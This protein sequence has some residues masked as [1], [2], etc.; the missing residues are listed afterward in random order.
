[1]RA[2]LA[3]DL[4]TAS[5]TNHGPLP[6]RRPRHHGREAAPGKRKA[7]HLVR[8]AGPGERSLVDGA[9]RPAPGRCA[10]STSSRRRGRT[11]SERTG[12]AATTSWADQSSSARELSRGA[13]PSASVAPDV[14]APLRRRRPPPH[15][16]PADCARD[17]RGRALVGCASTAAARRRRA[18]ADAARAS[19]RPRHLPALLQRLRRQRRVVL[20]ELSEL[21]G[22]R[23]PRR[24]R[25]SRGRRAG[26]RSGPPLLRRP[27]P[28]GLRHQPRRLDRGASAALAHP[29][30]ASRLL[31]VVPAA[32]AIR[33]GDRIERM[34]RVETLADTR[35]I[36][37]ALFVPP[38]GGSGRGATASSSPTR[39]ARCSAIL[40]S[41]RRSRTPSKPRA[42]AARLAGRLD[43]GARRPLFRV[44]VGEAMR[45][46]LPR[47]T[48]TVISGAA[49]GVQ[50][51]S[52]QRVPRRRSTPSV[53]A[54]PGASAPAPCGRPRPAQ[55]RRL[56][57]IPRRA[58]RAGARGRRPMATPDYL[59][60]LTCENALLHFEWGDEGV[61]ESALR[62]SAATTRP[63]SSSP[64]TTSTPSSTPTRRTKSRS[65]RL[66]EPDAD[67][68]R[69]R[70]QVAAR[71][72]RAWP[73]D[74]PRRAA[75][76]GSLPPARQ[77]MRPK[78]RASASSAARQPRRVARMRSNGTGEPPRC[79]WPSTVTRISC[80]MRGASSRARRSPAPP[81]RGWPS[82]ASATAGRRRGRRPVRALGDHHEREGLAARG[83]LLDLGLDR[84][85]PIGDLRHAG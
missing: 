70:D 27:P 64:R 54:F 24:R 37:S 53:P 55:D 21:G 20:P 40:A 69:G 85:D 44:E 72:R 80:S 67:R 57:P 52:T 10:S 28:D 71:G 17:P 13:V 73:V 22:S 32:T 2:D 39:S 74:A 35:E 82:P 65:A 45:R 36:W 63:T 43:L 46:A 60:C 47:A 68:A 19:A 84:L 42:R 77:T 11:A 25:P 79:R 3:V 78:R 62:R 38:R 41:V 48:L 75:R 58:R 26:R 23:G 34:V 1:M 51:E 31:L 56:K 14:R 5:V 29:G 8:G 7:P 15:C 50:W 6:A 9:T 61:V 59:I 12:P 30:L 83:A 49:H 76:R 4:A 18:L 16:A 66:A 81:R 33:T